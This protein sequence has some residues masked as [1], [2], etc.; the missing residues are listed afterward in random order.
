MAG[1]KDV[2]E[3]AGV[4][5]RTVGRVLNSTDFVEPT[6]KERV[7]SAARQ[8]NYRVNRRARSLKMG[9]SFEVV[10]LVGSVDELHLE[11]L[12][13]FETAMR[14][15]KYSLN[16]IFT[17]PEGTEPRD[18]DLVF[19]HVAESD[20]AGVA[21]FPITMLGRDNITDFC[22]ENSLPYVFLDSRELPSYNHIAID[23]TS[24]TVEAIQYLAAQGR[25]RIA[26]VGRQDDSSHF[27][28][29]MAGLTQIDQEPIILHYDVVTGDRYLRAR[30]AAD[31]F[32]QLPERPDA[33]QMYSDLDAMG[34][35]AGLHD[36]GVRIPEDVAIIG[37]DDRSFSRFTYPPLTTVA[38]P[39][40][41]VGKAAA[42]MLL[43][44][45]QGEGKA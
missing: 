12:M 44:H 20:P 6:T 39:S 25:K 3:L 35:M 2:A 16:V 32:L 30:A 21:V 14:E 1:L 11:K 19:K 26:Y 4:S 42:E 38:Q 18:R 17:F 33:V 28:G 43:R 34:F 37:F 15:A 31:R 41:E 36:A 29:Y 8:L 10:A 7:K 40:R 23:R 24:G 45:I 27:D 13:A 5:I 9:Q 22:A